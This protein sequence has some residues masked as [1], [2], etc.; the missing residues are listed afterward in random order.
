MDS[1]VLAYH[2]GYDFR[3][4]S[5]DKWCSRRA[6]KHLRKIPKPLPKLKSKVQIKSSRIYKKEEENK[7]IWF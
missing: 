2:I 1:I 4:Y 7:D 5:V 3:S 6:Q